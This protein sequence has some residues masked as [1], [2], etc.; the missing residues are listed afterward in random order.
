MERSR[1]VDVGTVSTTEPEQ[2]G[3]LQAPFSHP[4]ESKE[5]VKVL[6]T[7]NLESQHVEKRTDQAE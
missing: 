4:S 2:T 5:P 3:E 1:R 6:M 7:A